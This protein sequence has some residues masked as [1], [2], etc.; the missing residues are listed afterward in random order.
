MIMLMS[1][2]PVLCPSPTLG[3]T[4][5]LPGYKLTLWA[6]PPITAVVSG[7]DGHAMGTSA[8]ESSSRLMLRP[9]NASDGA[10]IPH[11]SWV[12]LRAQRNVGREE[13]EEVVGPRLFL[14][15][16]G[17]DRASW[18]PM[19]PVS[20]LGE[21]ILP[22]VLAGPLWSQSEAVLWALHCP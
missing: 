21:R 15:S 3:L 17:T 7:R 4:L 12:V 11:S 18:V 6:L 9:R 8:A 19:L 20:A 14:L 22:W 1:P 5:V 16:V 13:G 10:S 2:L